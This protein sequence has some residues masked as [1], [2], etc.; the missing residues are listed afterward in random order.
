MSKLSVD[1]ALIK[2]K[3]HIKK[4]EIAEAKKL[5]QA[6]LLTFP[7]N[8]RIQKELASLDNHVQDNVIQTPS[9][10][11]IDHLIN[12][13][14]QG[15]YANVVV[16]AH[17]LTK[18]YPQ[19]FVVWNIL[20]AG[21]KALGQ[22]EEASEAFKKVT[23]LNPNYADGYNNLGAALND[24]GKLDEA[25]EAYN[26]ALLIKPDYADVYN[27][28]GNTF[29]SLGKLNEAVEAYKKA[30]LFIPDSPEVHYN[31]GI[32]LKIQ[33]KYEEAI[34]TYDRALSLKPDYFE[35]YNNKGNALKD[36][37]KL[38]E[39]IKNYKK[40][41][42]L[43]PDYAEAHVN[44]SF[45]LL[46]SSKL[47]EGLDEY[48]WRRKNQKGLVSERH[49][50]LPLWDGKQ[51]LK[52]KKI[53]IWCEQGVGDTIN[54]SSRLSN[55]FS[56]A[57]HCILEC[58][59]KLVPLLERSFP[60]IKVKPENRSN[61]LDR[62]DFDFHLPMGSLY[63]HFI[64]DISQNPKIEPY[65]IPNLER[66]RYWKEQ[67]KSLGNGPYIGISW[68]SSDMSPERIPNYSSIEEW[69]PILKIPNATF[70]NLQYKDFEND[71]I[72][73]KDEFGVNV[74]NFD[75]IDHFDDIDDVAAL[76][77]ALDMVISNKTT[78]PFISGGVGTLT[79]LANWHQSSWNNILLNPMS[80][81]VK[82]YER[83]TWEPWDNIFNLIASNICNTNKSRSY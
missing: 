11:T 55:I 35:A 27:N 65:L 83:N 13:Y 64:E 75:D 78:I 26:K 66:V 22:I 1:Q 3:S 32:A 63:K 47:K 10:E 58:Q 45:V 70:I 43:K 59:E 18:E 51:S 77:K 46:N 79:K 31:L 62:E 20:G 19:A 73:I 67:L 52:D 56:Q 37:G 50:K 9:S 81:S 48:E 54:W 76:C 12:L 80:S 69:S 40:A 2:A 29:K 25:V 49:F 28:I 60:N 42:T 44:L 4:N 53:L 30:L 82:I 41:I 57:R 15:Q 68:K 72:K 7:K 14:N 36:Q 17:S 16:K 8:V 61:D 6:V 34:E 23:E 71:L 21:K 39:A 38:V 74:H 33:G 5:Y 24:Q